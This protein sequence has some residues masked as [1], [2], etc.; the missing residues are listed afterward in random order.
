MWENAAEMFP[1]NSL[2]ALDTVPY[3]TIQ[4]LIADNP[5]LVSTLMI[6]LKN[7]VYEYTQQLTWGADGSFSRELVDSVYPQFGADGISSMNAFGW[8]MLNKVINSQMVF[9]PRYNIEHNINKK[10][11][12]EEEIDLNDFLMQSRRTDLQQRKKRSICN[13]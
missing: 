1:N 10:E 5:K 6:G 12:K 7:G 3:N 11:T 8:K 2:M 9:A 4:E 13:A